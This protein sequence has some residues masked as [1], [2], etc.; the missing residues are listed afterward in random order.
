MTDASFWLYGTAIIFGW[1]GGGL[2]NW[3][4]DLLPGAPSWEAARQALWRNRARY[5]T[6]TGQWLHQRRCPHGE[7]TLTGPYPTVIF[8]SIALSVLMA[9]HWGWSMALGIAW[10]YGLFL[11]AVAVI[12]FE[13]HRVLNVM[14]AP[15]AVIVAL[16]SLLAVTPAPWEMLLGGL[17]GFGVFLLLAIIGRGALGMGDVK[18]AGVIGMM[19]GYPS[20]MTAL[21]I[22]ALLGGLAALFLLISRKAT[23][24]T[25]I[26]YAPY[27]AFGAIFAIW[28]M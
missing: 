16:F 22:G 3:A 6:P 1:I 19:V 20:V 17:V 8:A 21:I 4:A 5:W 14:L 25:A 10:L 18:L 24:K 7:E 15:A 12:D 11:L 27:L 26:A 2:V 13:H 28:M 9:W 23:R